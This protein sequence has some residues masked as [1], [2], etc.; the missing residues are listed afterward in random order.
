MTDD[1]TY[2]DMGLLEAIDVSQNVIIL[3]AA[4]FT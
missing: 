4:V 1:L 2:F 3:K